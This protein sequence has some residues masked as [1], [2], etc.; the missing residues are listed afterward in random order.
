MNDPNGATVNRRHRI[1]LAII[2]LAAII[3]TLAF[4]PGLV[5]GAEL[6]A[7]AGRATVTDGDTIVVAGRTV[8]LQGIDAPEIGQ[9]CRD[10]KGAAVRC[11]RTAA[12][13][14]DQIAG[15]RQ[16]VCRQDDRDAEDRYGRALAICAAG[17]QDI[18]RAMLAVGQAVAYRHYLNWPDGSPRPHREA[19]LAEET[20]ARAARRGL[21]AGEFDEPSAWRRAHPR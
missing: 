21:W 10:S 2:A 7:I 14:L 19:Y 9:Q 20:K 12:D 4:F 17:G 5:R 1:Y 3:Q 18:G 16:V 6:P 8:R 11:G 13:A 15:G